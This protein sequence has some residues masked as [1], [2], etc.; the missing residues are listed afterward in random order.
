MTFSQDTKEYEEE[1]FH[2][3][4]GC[5]FDEDFFKDIEE[6]VVNKVQYDINGNKKY[7]VHSDSQG[8]HK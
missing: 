4:S 1:K 7:L 5:S 3:Q 6:E 2:I 8:N